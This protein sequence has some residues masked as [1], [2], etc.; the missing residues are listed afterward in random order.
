MVQRASSDS[1]VESIFVDESPTI[2][3]RLVADS[4]CIMT[5]GLATFG[6][7]YASVRRSWIIC[8][9]FMMSVPR[10]N[11]MITDDK[12]V[13]EVERIDSS[14]GTPASNSS[15]LRVIRLSISVADSPVASV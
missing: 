4:G 11:V 9:A 8:R 12:P 15:R 2:M 3:K 5:G 1:S 13:T 14:H 10:S 7:V 6:R